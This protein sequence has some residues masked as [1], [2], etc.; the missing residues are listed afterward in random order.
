[1]LRERCLGD[2]SGS[3]EGL[4]MFISTLLLPVDWLFVYHLLLLGG[5]EL[6]MITAAISRR[7]NNMINL[8]ICFVVAFA[9][10]TRGLF[11]SGRCT[12]NSTGYSCI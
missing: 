5:V 10:L 11:C 8:A 1:M 3:G 9:A 12:C 6:V 4:T 7:D 2:W